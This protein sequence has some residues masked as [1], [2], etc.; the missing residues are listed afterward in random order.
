MPNHR[1]PS[2]DATIELASSFSDST[3]IERAGSQP[4]A[5]PWDDYG[6]GPE[7]ELAMAAAQS[8]S[9]GEGDGI[10][11]LLVHGPSGVGKSRLLAGLITERLRRQPE[12]A[13]A[14]LDA[15]TFAASCLEAASDPS[16]D[17][18]LALRHRLRGVNLFVL[19]DLESLERT[20]AAREELAHT[21][22]AL[23]AAGALVAFSS[24]GTPS[25]WPRSEWPARL[26]NRL[27]GGLIVRIDPAGLTSRRRYLLRLAA[28]AGVRLEAESIEML[29]RSAD[30]YRTIDGWVARLALEIQLR[31]ASN[32]QTASKRGR[33]PT[34]TANST[35][36]RI[37]STSLDVAAVTSILADETAIAGTLN[38]VEAVA[39]AVATRFHVRLS[40]L[41]GPSRRASIAP[42]RHLAMHI[43]RSQTGASFATIG[44]YFG[45]RDPATVRHAC[46]A[47]ADRI[48]A[49][50]SLAAAVAG[51]GR[52]D[53]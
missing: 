25:S 10:S 13:V 15:E 9:R 27:T 31:D 38:T 26:L 24:R 28:K 21:L 16:G 53:G 19:E 47:A 51:I 2:A 35:D 39:E 36:T 45:G 6:I 29:A 34:E 33:R 3:P 18:W 43:A 42:I 52:G 50:P 32:R 14:H 12:S 7:N 41:R 1:R 20:P 46:K 48:A 4:P 22:D 11:P 5:H 49:D 8:L 44:A 37:A 17:G 30:G 40:S 23:D